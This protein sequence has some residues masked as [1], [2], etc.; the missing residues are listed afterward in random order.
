MLPEIIS[1]EQILATKLFNVSRSTVREGEITYQRDLILHSG[2]AVIIPVFDDET[3]ALV[4]QYRH[5]AGKYLLE[6]PAGSLEKGE[7]PEICAAREVQEEI[8]YNAGKIEL[9]TEFYVSPGFLNEKMFVF[10]ATELTEVGQNLDDDEL[11][12]VERFSFPEIYQMIFQ[13]EFEDAKTM[14]GLILAGTKFGFNFAN[15]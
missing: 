12:S 10:L 2:S 14:L 1:S 13:G 11:L 4:R 6:L 5:A 3:V 15:S 7:S 9:L 8:G